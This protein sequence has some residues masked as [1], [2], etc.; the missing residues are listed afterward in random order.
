MNS[1]RTPRVFVLALCALWLA[2]CASFQGAPPRPEA[3]TG[4]LQ[5]LDKDYAEALAAYH[6]A[7]KPQ[8]QLKLRNQFIELRAGLIDRQYAAFRSTLYSQRVGSSVGVDIATMTLN[9]AGVLTPGE[10]AKTAANALSGGIIGSKASVDKNVYFDRTLTAMLSQMEGQRN[11][12]RFRMLAGMDEN[13]KSYP[14]MQAAADLE[15]YYA[16]GTLAGAVTT[17][18]QQAAVSEAKSAAALAARLPS[19]NEV[20]D[21]LK[22]QRFQVERAGESDDANKK[23]MAC[24][25]PGGVPN[26]D[27]VNV[28]LEWM[29]SKGIDSSPPFPA[30]RFQQQPEFA[31][32]RALAAAD[33]ALMAKF[34]ACK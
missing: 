24:L 29:K 22:K 6:K 1:L 2:G 10:H 21:K 9:I 7:D 17:M 28:L 20:T 30:T 8:D 11:E 15:A 34:K 19:E 3:A 12:I 26:M 23:L 33:T 4:G 31:A 14:L 25:S 32:Q 13:A 27:N 5:A 18:T 16:A